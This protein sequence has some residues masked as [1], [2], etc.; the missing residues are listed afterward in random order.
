MTKGVFHDS[1]ALVLYVGDSFGG[2]H[3]WVRELFTGLKFHGVICKFILSIYFPSFP[4]GN[5]N[6]FSEIS[7]VTGIFLYRHLLFGIRLWTSEY[8]KYLRN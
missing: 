8:G 7:L 4:N 1:H 3:S 2:K 5:I 6:C